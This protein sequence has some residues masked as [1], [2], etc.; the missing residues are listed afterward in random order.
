MNFVDKDGTT[1]V[2]IPVHPW[3]FTGCLLVLQISFRLSGIWIVGSQVGAAE[4]IGGRR[5]LMVVQ[6][7]SD[8]PCCGHTAIFLLHKLSKT[9]K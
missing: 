2:Y 9:S 8:H 5:L 4:L 3:N 6:L 1:K 7:T